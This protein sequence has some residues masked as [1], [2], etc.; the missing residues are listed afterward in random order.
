[1]GE[2]TLIIISP[3][4]ARSYVY[5]RTEYY[6]STHD[7][8]ST[9]KRNSV[10]VVTPSRYRRRQVPGPG[11][12]ENEENGAQSAIF[13]PVSISLYKEYANYPQAPLCYIN[14]G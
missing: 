2:D 7:D 10:G 12:G 14:V 1:M 4:R 9:R 5:T 11:P 8:S 6:P 3:A 13:Q